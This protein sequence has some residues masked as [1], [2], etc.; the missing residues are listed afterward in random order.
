MKKCLSLLLSLTMLLTSVLSAGIT[1]SAATRLTLNKAQWMSYEGISGVFSFVPEAEGDYYFYSIGNIDTYCQ[2]T[3]LYGNEFYSDDEIGSNFC[4][5][6]HLEAD[7]LYNF[8]VAARANQVSFKVVISDTAPEGYAPFKCTHTNTEIVSFSPAASDE[9]GYTGDVVC[10]DCGKLIQLGEVIARYSNI[11]LTATAFTYTG[12]SQKPSVIVTDSNGTLL[13]H[14]RDYLVTYPASSINT[15]KYTVKIEF[16]GN[17]N[18]VENLTYTIKPRTTAISASAAVN[19]FTVKW[20]K[21]AETTGYQIQY[22]T[23][24]D[25]SNAVTVYGG[26]VNTLSK[27]ISG[28]APGAN[29]Y[30][31]VRTYKNIGGGEYVWGNWSSSKTVTTK[32]PQAAAKSVTALAKGFKVSWNKIS[33]I[34]G[35]QVQYATKSDFSNAATVYAGN[36]AATSKTITNRASNTRYYVRVR[37][38]KNNGGKYTYG[39]WS[40]AKNIKTK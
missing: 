38:Y 4:I 25:F 37:A 30:I 9:D 6:Q 36:S 14:K 16:M 10:A 11:R 23:K 7:A 33:G 5:A 17:Y 28:C 34:T 1:A 27:T 39:A 31:R 8:T 40:A 22:S 26:A 12:K 3:D 2:F 18:G 13:K 19:G 21:I 24:S 32:V 29:Y 20:N 15:G 35:Y